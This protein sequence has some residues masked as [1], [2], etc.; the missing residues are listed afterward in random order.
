VGAQVGLQDKQI[1]HQNEKISQLTAMVEQ[2][3]AKK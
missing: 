2:L 3:M 1:E